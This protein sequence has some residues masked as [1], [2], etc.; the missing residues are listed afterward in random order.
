MN[1]QRLDKIIATPL[2]PLVIK[3]EPLLFTKQ[4]IEI[5]YKL[6]D[7]TKFDNINKRKVTVSFFFKSL[8]F[9]LI[10]SN[11]KITSK[12]HNKSYH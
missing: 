11:I 2:R 12:K 4:V 7:K 3:L 8:N 1:R 6:H 5:A 9:L 10:D